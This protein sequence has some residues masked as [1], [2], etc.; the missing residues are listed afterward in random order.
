[1]IIILY[2]M[3]SKDILIKDIFIDIRHYLS[4]AENIFMT[5][6]TLA[7]YDMYK[8]LMEPPI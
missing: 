7:F 6:V 3:T 2:G 1:M 8:V 4:H 5:V